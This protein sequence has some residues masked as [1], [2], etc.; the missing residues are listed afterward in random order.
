MDTDRNSA[1]RGTRWV[2]LGLPCSANAFAL[3]GRKNARRRTEL[4]F[5]RRSSYETSSRGEGGRWK[6]FTAAVPAGS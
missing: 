4:S 5:S 2:K 6:V 1:A 3:S